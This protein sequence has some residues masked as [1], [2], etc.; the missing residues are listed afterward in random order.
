MLKDKCLLKSL[1]AFFYQKALRCFTVCIGV[2]AV[3]KARE[4]DERR[5][6]EHSLAAGCFRATLQLAAKVAATICSARSLELSERPVWSDDAVPRGWWGGGFG[7]FLIYKSQVVIKG[8]E[9]LSLSSNRS[10][11]P[12]QRDWLLFFSLTRK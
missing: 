11:N 5:K 7:S 6:E 9:T 8:D 12:C 10:V 2:G 4:E 3:R 1:K